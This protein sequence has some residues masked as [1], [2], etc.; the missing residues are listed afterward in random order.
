MPIVTPL[1]QNAHRDTKLTQLLIAELVDNALTARAARVDVYVDVHQG[2]S[3]VLFAVCPRCIVHSGTPLLPRTPTSTA[4][5][6]AAD[7]SNTLFGWHCRTTGA[8]WMKRNWRSAS[9]KLGHVPSQ[10]RY[11]KTGCK[12]YSMDVLEDGKHGAPSSWHAGAKQA[13]TRA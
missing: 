10:Q 11:V 5:R 7:E 4:V 6:P 12:E 13:A 3:L 8:A 1:P 9:R 2:H